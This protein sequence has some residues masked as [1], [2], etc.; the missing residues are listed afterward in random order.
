MLV[1]RYPRQHG[2]APFPRELHGLASQLVV[3]KTKAPVNFIGAGHTQVCQVPKTEVVS[4]TSQAK[5]KRLWVGVGAV[6]D[7]PRQRRNQGCPASRF[8]VRSALPLWISPPTLRNTANVETADMC[9]RPPR[10]EARAASLDNKSAACSEI[11]RFACA[12]TCR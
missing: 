5:H 3:V 8:G 12:C 11:V 10:T 4:T 2:M 1:R 7:K 9:Q 6:G